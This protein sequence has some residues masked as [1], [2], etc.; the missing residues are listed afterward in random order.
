MTPNA[1]RR[2]VT[3]DFSA[4]P[5]PRLIDAAAPSEG[6]APLAEAFETIVSV[7]HLAKCYGRHEAVF[8]VSFTVRRGTIVGIL[9]PNGAGKTTTLRALLGL[10]EPTSGTALFVSTRYRDLAQPGRLVGAL[11]DANVGHPG[12]T[13][14]GHLGVLASALDVPRARVSTVLDQVGLA[15]ASKRRI[16]GFS[17]GMRQRL[18]LAGALLGEPEI[19]VLDEPSNGLDPDG[20]R[21]LRHTLRNFAAAGGTVLLSSHVL[22]EVAQTAD[23]IVVIDRGR[24][25]AQAPV[26]DFTASLGGETATRVRTPSLAA[27]AAALAAAGHEYQR[28]EPDVL[29]VHS[30]S[31]EELGRVA[32]GAGAVIYE[33]TAEGVDLETAFFNLTDTDG[34]KEQ[35]R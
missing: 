25:V 19:L 18:G 20:I 8:D 32:A 2:R 7:S 3:A 9:G 27:L 1:R 30:L 12:R 21:W 16:G 33:L 10:V 22:A 11:I 14:R 13:A 29:R 17:Q 35:Q 6:I 23:E 34:S 15:D 26:G 31:P 24:V 4:E 5:F 28:L